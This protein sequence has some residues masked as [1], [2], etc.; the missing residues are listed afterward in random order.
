MAANLI[1]TRSISFQNNNEALAVSVAARGKVEDAASALNLKTYKAVI[2]IIG[3]AD[4]VDEKL[5]PRLTQL[6]GRGV[7]RAAAD[8]NALIV[9]GGV[10]G[11][12][13]SLMGEGVAGR[14]YK[15]PLVGVAPADKV[16][17]PG[18]PA[19]GVQLE[20]NHTHFVLVNGDGWGSATAAMFKLAAELSGKP[21][22]AGGPERERRKQESSKAAVKVPAL[23]VL[24]GGGTDAKEGVLRSV[25]QNIPLI[26]IEGSGGLADEIAAAWRK[27][28]EMTD[29]PVMAEIVADGEI[30]LHSLANSVKGIERLIIRELGVDKVLM[31]AWEV[32]ADYDHNANLQQKRFSVLQFSI[33]L[34]GV[35]GTALAII[36]QIY[37]P[38][39]HDTHELLPV[40]LSP[41]PPPD[42]SG[43]PDPFAH[44]YQWWLLRHSLIILPILLTVLVTA[45]NRFKQGNKWMLLRAGAESIKREIYRYRAR[46]MY[47]KT[48]AE[49]QL[50]Q[51]LE[52]ITRRTMR[53]EVNLS[54]L[55]PYDKD[56]GFPPYMYASQGGDDGFSYLTPDRYVE[57]RLGDQLSYFQRKAVK[58]ERQLK[59]LYWMTF[60]IGGL[61]AYLAAVE[62]QAWIALTTA[63]VAAIGTYLGYRQTESTLTKY[64]Q[65][66]TDLSNVKAWWNALSAEE[67]SLQS[68]IDS[69]VEHTEQVLQTELDGWVQQMQNALAELRKGQEPGEDT[70]EQ[71]EPKEQNAA[72]KTEEQEAQDKQ[73][74]EPAQVKGNGLVKPP[75][76]ANGKQ[77]AGQAAAE[78]EP[79][80]PQEAA[81]A[82]QGEES[83]ATGEAEQAEESKATDEAG[84]TEVNEVAG[85]SD[86]NEEASESD[87]SE[88]ASESQ[89]I[90]DEPEEPEVL[91][92]PDV[93][94]VKDNGA[95][96]VVSGSGKDI[97]KP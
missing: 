10:Q 18:G 55:K 1:E 48:N 66:A 50:S 17:Y 65:A 79:K 59:A 33:L 15:S 14:G 46:A 72:P 81:A 26:V 36:Q 71:R 38:Q 75:A 84:Q 20:P 56:K 85:S 6:F 35:L 16:T 32:F 47:Y 7:A 22:G 49:Q 63:T 34:L 88:E 62:E 89:P 42:P 76:E 5:R 95:E 41:A 60:I 91:L 80:E 61:G 86:K 45:A 12:V 58:L 4:G 74:G 96:P 11:G 67:Q 27:K 69:L 54:A 83:K 29:D 9:D 93:T 39:N 31:Q 87:E 3:G 51:K 78:G 68:N 28:D 30:N 43:K 53:T 92:E 37:A 24:A 73:A 19:E 57:V 2:V 13:M 44:G 90:A 40:T 8:A 21:A 25:R 70:E 52:D 94:A 64:N 97:N 82:K 23:A 77:P